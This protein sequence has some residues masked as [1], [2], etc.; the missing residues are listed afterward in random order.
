[1]SGNLDVDVTGVVYDSRKVRPGSVFVAIRGVRTD[2]NRFVSQAL[3]NGAAAVVSAEPGTGTWIEVHDER[4]SL[5]TIAANFYEHPTR[6]LDL[7]GVTGT[8]GKTTTTYIIESILSAAG[9]PSAIFGTIE[10]RGPG[11]AFEAER[12]TPEAPD[13][14]QLFRRVVDAGWKYSVMEVSSHAIALKRVGGLRFAAAVFT[15]LSR[16]HLDFH[17]S[18]RS[19]FLA[20]KKLF[21]GMGDGPPRFMVLNSDDETYTELR[22]IAPERVIS[23]GMQ[24]ASNIYPLNH[25]FGWEGTE[26]VFQ[27]PAGT[28][29]VR[30][31]LMGTPNL[32]NMGAAIG[33]AVGFGLPLK[34]IH[35]GIEA[36]A[37]VPGRFDP[38]HA[39]QP[40]RV[41]VDYAHTDDA[42][43]KVLRSA[44]EITTRH[45]IVVF[46][47]GGD[48]DRTKRPLMGEAAARGADRIVVTSDN[49]RSEDPLEIIHEIE[50]G[51][52]RS[53]AAYEVEPDRR[54]AIRKALRMAQ[55]G[56]T[57]LIAGKGHEAYQQIGNQTFP[58]DDK[59]VARELL[60]ELDAGR[61][62]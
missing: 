48:R 4:E 7:I 40:F 61:N 32:Y 15:N 54:E 13:L 59:A 22:A 35:H 23:Y 24:S 8:N 20:K 34:A 3:A 11:F 28:V 2:G 30:S 14:E 55:A 1:M 39:G 46:G 9:H 29:D 42:L 26:A 19:Y 44:R 36:L 6:S 53:G 21:T 45:L 18:M 50:V 33:V 56:D 12:T 41:L 37:N 27:T 25:Q 5:A 57:V 17:G 43:E 10:Y 62:H 47:C 49:P 52:K 31:R 51:L 60:D 38:V 16:D 58:F